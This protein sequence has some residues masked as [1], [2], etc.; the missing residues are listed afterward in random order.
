MPEPGMMKMIAMEAGAGSDGTPGPM[1]TARRV[2]AASGPEMSNSAMEASEVS[3][4]VKSAAAS[5]MSATAPMSTAPMSTA[6]RRGSRSRCQGS[7]K[8]D[9]AKQFQSFHRFFSSYMISAT[10]RPFA[11]HSLAGELPTTPCSPS[12][13]SPSFH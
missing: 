8:S 10:S 4:T 11:G 7:A 12:A 9:H 2:E 6:T 3:T 5:E 13:R 1:E